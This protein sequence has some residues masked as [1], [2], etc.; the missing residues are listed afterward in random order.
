M[1]EKNGSDE[2]LAGGSG[3]QPTTYFGGYQT[4]RPTQA[5]GGNGTTQAWPPQTGVRWRPERVADAPLYHPGCTCPRRIPPDPFADAQSWDPGCEVHF[6]QVRVADAPPPVVHGGGSDGGG[7]H[8]GG[9]GSGGGWS[10]RR[11]IWTAL[12]ALLGALVLLGVVGAIVAPPAPKPA[13]VPVSSSAQPVP[14]APKPTVQPTTAPT[15]DPAPPV[16]PAPPATAAVP[17]PEPVVPSIDGT[18][19]F[20]V[21]SDVKPGTYRSAGPDADRRSLGLPCYWSRTRGTTGD[22]GD[23]IANG[24]PAGP[25][26]VTIRKS[27]GAFTSDGCQ[28]WVLVR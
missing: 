15:T 25:A 23:I 18:G 7:G 20:L 2:E 3:G 21:G 27:D 17:K 26:V 24:L 9:D 16:D 10:R 8:H 4:T 14:P 19:T 22:L 5:R 12:A 13:P 28:K 11:K 6:R 1:D